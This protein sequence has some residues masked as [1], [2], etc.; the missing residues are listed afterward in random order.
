VNAVKHKLILQH[1]CVVGGDTRRTDLGVGE[2][3]THKFAPDLVTNSY[4]Y[5]TWSSTAGSVWPTDG[6]ETTFTAP[7]NASP[8]TVTAVL[9]N[10]Q[11]D[12]PFGVAQPSGIEATLRGLPDYYWPLP[13][14]GAGMYMN[15][16]I[17]PTNVSF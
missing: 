4:W 13:A 6:N 1:Y 11:V 2:R 12:V 16:V 15:V 10:E 8:A 3:V 5:N 7:S 9:G 14:V 17:Q